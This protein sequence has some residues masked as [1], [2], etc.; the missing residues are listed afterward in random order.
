MGNMSTQL[1]S[2]QNKRLNWQSGCWVWDWKFERKKKKLQRKRWEREKVG[3]G[4]DKNDVRANMSKID[5]ERN[6]WKLQEKRCLEISRQ[7]WEI[8]R[9]GQKERRQW[10][11]KKEKKCRH[12][13]KFRPVSAC[14]FKGPVQSYLL[15]ARA[16]TCREEGRESEQAEVRVGFRCMGSSG[17]WSWALIMKE[18]EPLLFL[19]KAC[20][21]QKIAL[22]F[23]PFFLP[24]YLCFTCCPKPLNGCS[25]TFQLLCVQVIIFWPRG[26]YKE[27]I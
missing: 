16:R 10:K 5:C 19:S 15:S 23:F 8:R 18:A 21:D 3:E 14:N 13:C 20:S 1:G 6:K 25:K 27:E 11:A 4:R 24:R 12:H 17:G 7:R 9:E 22:Y 26:Y 2:R